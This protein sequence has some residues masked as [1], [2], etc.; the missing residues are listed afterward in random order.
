MKQQKKKE[1]GLE[2][3]LVDMETVAFLMR[4]SHMDVAALAKKVEI[5]A[6]SMKKWL[7]GADQTYFK[8]EL[9]YK[10]AQALHTTVD[11]ILTY[12]CQ[13]YTGVW[14]EEKEKNL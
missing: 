11:T 9:A 8:T 1:E 10:I 6:D 4:K 5:G 12:E 7:N 3:D 14:R 2:F 13:V